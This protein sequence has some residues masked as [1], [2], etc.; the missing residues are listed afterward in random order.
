MRRPLP[1]LLLSWL[2]TGA[3]AVLG[4]ILGNAAGKRGLMVGALVGGVLGL[5]TVVTLAGRLAWL[6][7]SELAGALVGGLLGFAAA[8]AL[9]LLN[10]H[11]PVVPVLSGALVGAG[12][13]I[14]AGA[15][16]ATPR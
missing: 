15:A 14:G 13:L 9:T 16:R 12:V 5:L 6:S 1:I 8:A 10:M 7:R 3:G 2:V 11:T 4:S